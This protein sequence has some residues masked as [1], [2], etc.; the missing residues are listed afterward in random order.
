MRDYFPFYKSFY[1]AI[2]ELPRDIQGEIYTAIIEY[3]LYGNEIDNLKPIAR[4]I[5]LLVKPVLE[6][7]HKRSDAG[8][9]GGAP[10]GNKNN[11]FSEPTYNQDTT[12]IQPIIDK[13]IDKEKEIECDTTHART[14][15][16]IGNAHK[17]DS[18]SWKE[19]VIRNHTLTDKDIDEII[20]KVV[21]YCEVAVTDE[22]SKALFRKL[23]LKQ[24]EMFKREPRGD[25]NT[26]IEALLAE[27]REEKSL[28]GYSADM[29][30]AFFSYW[31]QED[32]ATGSMR[33]EDEKYWNTAK[34]LTQWNNKT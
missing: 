20:D 34:R 10:K 9:K 18:Y 7:F 29:C 14:W 30:N 17:N 32:K 4:S 31:T 26:R 33:F 19:S 24:L 8:K 1:E 5:F 15:I 23:F 6:A 3:G 2:K 28:N 27:M 16:D 22:P 25:K 13:E 21:S 11:R 12:K